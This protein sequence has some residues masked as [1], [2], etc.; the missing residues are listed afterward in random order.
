MEQRPYLRFVAGFTLIAYLLAASG[1]SSFRRVDRKT[2]GVDEFRAMSADASHQL[3]KDS[4]FLKVHMH[5]GNLYV[6]SNWEARDAGSIVTGQG[7]LYGP[8]RNEIDAGN[9]TVGVDS[10]ALFETNVVSTSPLVG[11]FAVAGLITVGIAVYC[12]THEKACFGS[13]PTFYVAGVDSL[14]PRAEGFSSSIAPS[15]EASDIDDLCLTARGGDS[16]DLEM[17]NEAYETHVVRH[18]DLLAVARPPGHRVFNDAGGRFWSAGELIEPVS[19]SGPE[20]D[21]LSLLATADGHERFSATDS[22]D[23]RTSEFMDLAFPAPAPG[24]AGIVISCRQT[25]LTTYLLYQT[26]A[27]MGS[28]A[29]RWLAEIERGNVKLKRGFITDYLGCIDVQVA[30]TSGQ[31]VDVGHVCEYGPIATDTHVIPLDDALRGA[32][33]VRLVMTRGNWRV[34]RVALAALDENPEPVRIHP[35]GV[36]RDDHVDAVALAALL[37]S[38]RVLTTF[39]GD[40]Y[41]MHYE[42][43]GHDEYDLFVEA[44]GYYLEWI[45]KEWLK[46]ENPAALAEMFLAPDRAMTRLAPEFKRVEGSMEN[47]FWNSRYERH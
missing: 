19:A 37:D 29:G 1:C 46:E 38:T 40:R 10:I 5:G 4:P 2:H 12:L 8:N 42:L 43:P 44:R 47:Q 21:C 30:D 41:T 36:R 32:T 7:I 20:G 18:V 27:Y 24:H 34:D 22:T 3:A 33:R 45:R 31:F 16:I 9:F 39:P 25:L 11:I 23:L 17:R 15:L 35:A 13:C 14:L 26:F 6:L 28:D